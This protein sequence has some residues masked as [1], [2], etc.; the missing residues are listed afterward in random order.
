MRPLT[1]DNN[2]NLPS[3]SDVTLNSDDQLPVAQG[4]TINTTKNIPASPLYDTAYD[5]DDQHK[6]SSKHARKPV[7]VS[8]YSSQSTKLP[9]LLRDCE[10]Y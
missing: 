3:K 7:T 8:K 5:D 1:V 6:N 2:P 9:F 4:N 10:M